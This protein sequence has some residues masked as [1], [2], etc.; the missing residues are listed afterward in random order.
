M[1]SGTPELE[2]PSLATSTA[3]LEVTRED[4][5]FRNV[6]QGRVRI[7]VTVH[8]RGG[9]W[10]A[11]TTMRIEAAP[12]GAFVRPRPLAVLKVPAIPPL[13]CVNVRTEVDETPIETLSRVLP[14]GAARRIGADMDDDGLWEDRREFLLA[15]RALRRAAFNRSD[16]LRLPTDI[17]KLGGHGSLQWAGSLGVFVDKS[18]VERHQAN[19]LRIAPGVINYSWCAIGNGSRDQYRVTVEA[20]PD[21]EYELW[22]P[23]EGDWTEVSQSSAALLVKPPVEA[24][25]GR[26]ALHVEQASSGKTAI[27]EF[28]FDADAAG[29]GCPT[30]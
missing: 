17:L 10:S 26:F 4:I 14:P 27:V 15:Q 8:N 3:R 9:S 21:W 25:H 18:E 11:A 16:D 30:L 12:F 20:E 23:I 29:P 2:R 22:G 6:D 7:T 1:A 24:R 28:G 5:H 19:Q 13:R